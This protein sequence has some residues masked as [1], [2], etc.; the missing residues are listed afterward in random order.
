VDPLSHFPPRE[1]A[2]LPDDPERLATPK[3]WYFMIAIVAIWL[4]AFHQGQQVWDAMPVA[5]AVAF[6][7]AIT[8]LVLEQTPKR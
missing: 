1:R 4:L 6:L 5:T 3:L 7:Q 8:V 2:A